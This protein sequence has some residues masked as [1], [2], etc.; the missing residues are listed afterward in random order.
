MALKDR[1]VSRIEDQL[2]DWS[3]RLE[4][5]RTTAP[6]EL[7]ERAELSSRK[8]AQARE[9]LQELKESAHGR[10]GALRDRVELAW[11]ELSASIDWKAIDE[12][13]VPSRLRDALTRPPS[14]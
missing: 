10:W 5:L 1:Y 12:K 4:R 14:R 2:A 7:R 8:L 9:R 13:G 3:A 6:A 11:R